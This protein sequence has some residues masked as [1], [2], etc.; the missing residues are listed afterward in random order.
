MLQ[1]APA[2]NTSV[3]DLASSCNRSTELVIHLNFLYHPHAI[4]KILYFTL[5]LQST[6]TKQ[7]KKTNIDEDKNFLRKNLQCINCQSLFSQQKLLF[8]PGATRRRGWSFAL[9]VYW[10]ENNARKTRKN[11]LTTRNATKYNNTIYHSNTR[12]LYFIFCFRNFFSTSLL[13]FQ[14]QPTL[15]YFLA[16]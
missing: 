2:M 11:S 1:Q 8:S 15:A 12:S 9:H 4:H 3:A 14:H 7:S 6:L 13:F 5:K 10:R 16:Y